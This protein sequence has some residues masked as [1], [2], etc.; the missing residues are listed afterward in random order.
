MSEVKNLGLQKIAEMLG[1]VP[2]S[3]GKN[4][5]NMINS[6]DLRY[7]E[8]QNG[9]EEEFI[10]DVLKKIDK[11]TQIIGA[12][13]RTNVWYNGWQENLKDFQ[14]KKDK[15]SIVPKF[16]RPNN[17]VR[18][19]GRFCKTINPFFERD[20]A[21]VI[22]LHLY[23]KLITE[24][25]EE[26]HEFGCGSGFNLMNL[27]EVNK[28]ISLHGSDFVE[29]SV[30]LIKELSSHYGLNLHSQLFNMLK[31]DYTYQIGENSCVFTHG[32]IEQLDSK[33][34][35]F[36]DFLIYK[37]PKICFHIEPVCEVYELNTLF[38]YSQFMFHKKR[39]YTSGLLPY[40]QEKQKEG[41]IKDLFFKRPCFGSKFMEGYTIISWSPT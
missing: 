8:L 9:D 32:S 13:E 29:S 38:D 24:D 4:C 11:D 33:F 3:L 22:Q 34:E 14:H 6:I 28:R 23:D 20:F 10:L 2:E 37:K 19:N 36:V 7:V 35:R 18:L 31:P 25:I 39:G 40:L 5:I 15:L 27:S 17:V 12:P 26:V 21:K 16:I 41:V 30:K 1:T